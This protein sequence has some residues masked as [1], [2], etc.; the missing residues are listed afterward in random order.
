MKTY[1]IKF[2]NKTYTESQGLESTYH[3]HHLAKA[4]SR[5]A[6]DQSLSGIIRIEHDRKPGIT[7]FSYYRCLGTPEDLKVYYLNCKNYKKY[8]NVL[9]I[10]K[11]YRQYKRI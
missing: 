10:Q 11:N 1:E 5:I 9:T 3:T 6:L 7:R 8:L 2:S 4:Y